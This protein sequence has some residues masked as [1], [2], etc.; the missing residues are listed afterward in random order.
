MRRI[1][2]HND[3]LYSIIR[4]ISKHNFERKGVDTMELLKEFRDYI[5]ANHVIKDP[6]NYTFL[7]EVVELDFEE[8][9]DGGG[10]LVK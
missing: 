3:K 10:E 1:L 2:N 6:I 8:V 7:E 5:G 9:I 4:I